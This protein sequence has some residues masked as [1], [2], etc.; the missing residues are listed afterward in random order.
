MKINLLIGP[1]ASGK[2]TYINSLEIDK[3]LAAII[4]DPSDFERDIL[5]VIKDYKEVYIADPHLCCKNVLASAMQRLHSNFP[6]AEF[7]FT[8]FNPP[9]Y[10]LEKNLYC[11]NL[12]DKRFIT[13]HTLRYFYNE[14]Q[15]TIEWLKE[16]EYNIKTT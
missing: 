6:E 9:F 1:P 13:T 14:L 15:E 4:D 16:N 7:T 12:T 2:T 10:M 8:V 11:R 3:T 5:Y